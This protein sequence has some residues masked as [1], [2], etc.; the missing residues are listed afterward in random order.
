MLVH[1]GYNTEQ[2]KTLHDFGL[3]DLEKQKWILHK[4][5]THNEV[6]NKYYR[7]DDLHFPYDKGTD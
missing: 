3:F 2:K 7:I 6:D 4:V 5:Y 1:G